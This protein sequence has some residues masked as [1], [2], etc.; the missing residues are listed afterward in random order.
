MEQIGECAAAVD[1]AACGA[2]LLVGCVVGEVAV[3]DTAVVD[4]G[5]RA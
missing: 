2:N 1:V 4:V 3:V 5:C